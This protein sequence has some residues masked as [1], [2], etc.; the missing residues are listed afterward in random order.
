MGSQHGA[1][2]VGMNDVQDFPLYMYVHIQCTVY[3]YV[4]RMISYLGK[5]KWIEGECL[6][7]FIC[8]DLDEKCPGWLCKKHIPVHI[9]CTNTHV[10]VLCVVIILCIYKKHIPVDIQC[11]NTHVHAHVLSIAIYMYMYT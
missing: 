3:M 4:L 11:T 6:G 5:V 2:S 8:H 1:R 10:H 7:L 9:Q